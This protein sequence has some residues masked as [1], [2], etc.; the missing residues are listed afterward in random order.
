MTT[1]E[2]VYEDDWLTATLKALH[3]AN[4]QAKAISRRGMSAMLRDEYAACHA[5]INHLLFEL[6][7]LT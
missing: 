3:E 5:T 6:E 1:L 7:T 4:D 2:V